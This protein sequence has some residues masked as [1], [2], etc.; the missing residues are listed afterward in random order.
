MH[1]NCCIDL[2]ADDIRLYRSVGIPLDQSSFNRDLYNVSTYIK[3]NYLRTNTKKSVVKNFYRSK[4]NLSFHY[5][6][7]RSFVL[8]VSLVKHLDVLYDSRI[9]FIDYL[10]LTVNKAN[11]I[12]EFIFWRTFKFTDPQSI[13]CI[14]KSLVLP[15]LLY[16]SYI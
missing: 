12:L 14:Y 10:N 15:V 6:L 16:C 3:E 2:F 1:I 11:K 8:S 5:E 9:N 13:L 7:N 4:N